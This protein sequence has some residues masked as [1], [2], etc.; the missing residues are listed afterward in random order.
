VKFKL[1]FILILI[2]ASFKAQTINF[3]VSVRNS[4]CNGFNNGSAEIIV[5]ETN[6]PYTYLWNFGS[7]QR[8]VSGLAPGNYSV[9]IRDASGNDTLTQV[10][11]AESPCQIVPAIIFTPNNDSY[12][13]TWSIVNIEYYPD[14]LILVFNR[15]G[16]KVF[17]SHG[18]YEPWD[19]RDLLNIP[20]P[21]NSYYYIIYADKKDKEPTIKGTISIIR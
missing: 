13:D 12:N 4:S 2:A 5:E 14:N 8:I 11:I 16:Q 6:P 20:L 15:W 17:E 9:T 3:S 10:T 7:E 19:G 18:V 21:D 1:L